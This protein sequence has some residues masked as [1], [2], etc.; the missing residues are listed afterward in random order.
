MGIG[1]TF[2]QHRVG[3][4]VPIEE[5]V[6]G[7]MKEGTDSSQQGQELGSFRSW[8]AI[9]PSRT[10]SSVLTAMRDESAGAGRSASALCDRRETRHTRASG[11]RDPL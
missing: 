10:R 3:P 7:T 5:G 8:R 2:C 6:A 4:N 1:P 9:H 11:E